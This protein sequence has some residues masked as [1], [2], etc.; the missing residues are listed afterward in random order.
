MENQTLKIWKEILT[1]HEGSEVKYEW[2]N[3]N[4]S[5]KIKY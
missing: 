4:G 2:W 5:W 1:C 3:P